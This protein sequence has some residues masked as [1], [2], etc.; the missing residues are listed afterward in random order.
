MGPPS[1]FFLAV[2]AIVILAFAI[3]GFISA[4]NYK[5]VS[6]NSTEGE[7]IDKGT[8]NSL[9]TVMIIFGIVMLIAFIYVVYVIFTYDNKEKSG[10]DPRDASLLAKATA[11]IAK[12][13]S[14]KT[15]YKNLQENFNKYKD[16]SAA[17]NKEFEKWDYCPSPRIKLNIKKDTGDVLKP[18]YDAEGNIT[19]LILKPK[20]N[21]VNGCNEYEVIKLEMETQACYELKDNKN[22]ADKNSF[23]FGK[24][25]MTQNL[26]PMSQMMYPNM[27]T[28]SFQ[29]SNPKDSS[30]GCK[31]ENF[32]AKKSIEIP[33]LSIKNCGSTEVD[34]VKS[35][36][37]GIFSGI[38]PLV[39]AQNVPQ[40]VGLPPLD[41]NQ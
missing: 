19:G 14:V 34:K 8:A 30:S 36:Y 25:G 17:K 4:V 22:N 26:G 16:K 32:L 9:S 18:D 21:V 37:P 11:S 15:S 24:G 10:I 39:N 3:I 2:V 13:D 7:S 23:F 41:Q 38:N 33:A 1:S 29:F 20:K 31:S 12:L 28:S 27:A 35:M 5:N 40:N 6:N